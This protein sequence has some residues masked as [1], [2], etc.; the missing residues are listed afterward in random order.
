MDART[1]HPYRFPF[2]S[3]PWQSALRRRHVVST[4]YV[5]MG[6]SLPLVVRRNGEFPMGLGGGEAG[7]AVSVWCPLPAAVRVDQL[8]RPSSTFC[9]IIRHRN[10]GS[11][12]NDFN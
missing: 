5:E 2:L 1:H 8:F 4:S 7:Q 10:H 12:V 6:L 11:P 9:R 3:L